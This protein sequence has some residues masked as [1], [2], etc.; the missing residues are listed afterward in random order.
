MKYNVISISLDEAT[1]Q[2]LLARLKQLGMTRSEY[3]RSLLRRDGVTVATRA[4]P[5]GKTQRKG[6]KV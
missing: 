2:G 3:V 5:K 1:R 6:A 4:T